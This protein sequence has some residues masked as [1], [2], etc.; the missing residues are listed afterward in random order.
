MK[1]NYNNLCVYLCNIYLFDKFFF[2][3]NGFIC[4][5]II[6]YYKKRFI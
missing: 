5:G 3:I 2:K 4:N 1:I 6:K